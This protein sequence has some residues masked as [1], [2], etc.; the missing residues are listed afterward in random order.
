MVEPAGRSLLPFHTIDGRWWPNLHLPA[1]LHLVRDADEWTRLWA[2]SPF[3][4]PKPPALEVNWQTEMCVVA[5]LGTRPNGGYFVL[6]DTIEVNGGQ[7]MVLVWEIRPGP[8]CAT[9][10]GI[11]FPFHAVSAPAHA[12]EATLF[13]RIAYEDCKPIE[14]VQY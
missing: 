8:G 6:I 7:I 14:T 4:P 13:K 1:G 5:A 12:G 10:R 11:T 2:R 9:T 3:C